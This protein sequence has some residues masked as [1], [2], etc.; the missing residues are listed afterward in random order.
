MFELYCVFVVGIVYSLLFSARRRCR[1]LWLLLLLLPFRC[2][3]SFFFPLFQLYS[4][5]LPVYKLSVEYA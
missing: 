3:H 5:P 1:L 2:H 4:L